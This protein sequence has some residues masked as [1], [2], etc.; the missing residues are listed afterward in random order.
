MATSLVGV[1]Q[2]GDPV[3]LKEVQ[4]TSTVLVDITYD[5]LLRSKPEQ[6]AM[7]RAYHKAS[8]ASKE[9]TSEQAAWEAGVQAGIRYQKLT[10]AGKDGAEV[11]LVKFAVGSSPA[12]SYLLTK[13]DAVT[14]EAI[15]RVSD[16]ATD[17]PQPSYFAKYVGLGAKLPLDKLLADVEGAK[18]VAPAPSQARSQGT[19]MT[20]VAGPAA[21][22]APAPST[23]TGRKRGAD[24]VAAATGDEAAG[25]SSAKKTKTS[26]AAAAPPAGTP[27][28]GAAAAKSPAAAKSAGGDK[29]AAGAAAAGGKGAASGKASTAGKQAAPAAKKQKAGEDAKEKGDKG[30]KE[31][32][33]APAAAAAAAPK[34]AGKASAAAAAAADKKAAAAAAAAEKKAAAAK[35]PASA[36]KKG[37][38]AAAGAKTPKTGGK[39]GDLKGRQVLVPLSQ[40]PDWQPG[41]G[42]VKPAGGFRGAVKGVKGGQA[43]VAV[44]SVHKDGETGA[45]TCS[46]KVKEVEKW[47]VPVGSEMESPAYTTSLHK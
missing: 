6:L 5:K 37:G 11:D 2:L 34:S 17:L 47:L 20:G 40:W 7:F 13:Q 19:V 1:L 22:P 8:V 18:G 3:T 25:P 43:D 30:E 31:E 38:A 33:E 45:M 4:K 44:F 24:A 9:G 26:A 41:P 29:K 35:T 16:A 42:E 36:G 27:A 21:A 28:K 15:A 32:E 23:N 10:V 14:Y 12:T 39:A 46:W